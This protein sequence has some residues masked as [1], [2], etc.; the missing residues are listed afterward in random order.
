MTER[1]EFVAEL[2]DLWACADPS[3]LCYAD[4]S[5]GAWLKLRVKGTVA[6]ALS[7]LIC[8]AE[9]I[10]IDDGWTV[11][12]VYRVDNVSRMD[13]YVEFDERYELPCRPHRCRRCGCSLN[14]QDEWDRNEC[15]TCTY[16]EDDPRLGGER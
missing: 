7:G 2:V 13:V 6:E 14:S 4:G 3:W 16:D 9:S 12:R 5:F 15:G 8:V 1:R 10:G 11:G